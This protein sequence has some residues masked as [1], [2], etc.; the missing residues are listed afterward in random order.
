LTRFG[1]IILPGNDHLILFHQSV[2]C[3]IM[4]TNGRCTRT[5]KAFS[6]GEIL[7]Y[8]IKRQVDIFST[9]NFL[10]RLVPDPDNELC[11]KRAELI[12]QSLFTYLVQDKCCPRNT[13][14]RTMSIPS[15]DGSVNLKQIDKKVTEKTNFETNNFADHTCAL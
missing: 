5:T 4:L 10:S 7:N 9:S 1:T 3:K 6:F 15:L 8:V 14:D 2:N 12:M 13:A 11:L